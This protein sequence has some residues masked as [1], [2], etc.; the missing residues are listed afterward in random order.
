M[1]KKEWILIINPKA[2]NEKGEKDLN[3]ITG[4][5]EASGISHQYIF[6]EYKNHAKEIIINY[7]NQGFRNFIIGG[8]DG[9]LNEAVNGIFS[10]NICPTTDITLAVIPIGTGN[11]WRRT[12]K[13]STDYKEAVD[14]IKQENWK[15]QDVGKVIYTKANKPFTHYFINIA[16]LGF[17]AVVVDKTN[18]HKE[19]SR[20]KGSGNSKIR[21][22]L[23]VLKYLL[24]YKKTY[25]SIV[26]DQDS[27]EG[28]TLS[29]AVCI[30][31]YNGG[32]M[33]PAPL[34][35]SDDGLFDLTIFTNVTK[36][37]VIFNVH[38]L[39]NGKIY[40]LK[41]VKLIR[42]SEV[43]IESTPNVLIE[44][45][46]EVLASTPAIFTIIPRCLKIITSA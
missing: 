30:G 34:S 29:F 24:H 9:T 22:L 36:K 19:K 25:C 46:G 43:K 2:G 23:N 3:T 14:L 27:Y 13:I 38:K 10:Q 15:L 37:E 45:D 5:L 12:Y 44:A 6:T 20:K 40:N 31:K 42:C 17:D 1:E 39:F 4:L 8:G 32:G 21:Y 18:I 16:G 35:V 11:D 41:K 33:M 28:I 7:I 26:T